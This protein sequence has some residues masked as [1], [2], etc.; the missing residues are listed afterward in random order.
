MGK[1]A[2][3]VNKKE[4]SEDKKQEIKD[5]FDLFDTDGS[6]AIDY[7]ELKAALQALGMPAQKEDID[8]FIALADDDDAF[9]DPEEG[10]A[11][12]IEFDEF[13]KCLTEMMLNDDP[14]KSYQRAFGYF[15]DT[16]T[17]TFN[18]NDLQRIRQMLGHGESDEEL[19]EMLQVCSG[20][21]DVSVDGNCE[22]DY[23]CF[24][25]FCEK[26]RVKLNF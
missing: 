1:K 20:G 24:K 22:M 9:G 15:D 12:E 10:G 21:V 23:V 25:K 7:K 19:K 2:E 14:E 6:G 26:Q 8:K 13:L 3:S 17:G 4:L 5:A 18:L 11:G 16:N